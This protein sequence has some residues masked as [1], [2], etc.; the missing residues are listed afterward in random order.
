M[1]NSVNPNDRIGKVWEYTVNY[2]VGNRYLLLSYDG[3]DFYFSKVVEFVNHPPGIEY[4]LGSI[5]RVCLGS[6]NGQPDY[7]RWKQVDDFEYWVQWVRDNHAQQ[8]A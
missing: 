7:S 1:T 5:H 8:E 4:A 3:D 6:T 2:E